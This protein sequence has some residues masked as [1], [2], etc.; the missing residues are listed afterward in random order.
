MC[1]VNY[2]TFTLV[3]LL[4]VIV[5]I[6]ILASV[7][8][9]TVTNAIVQARD[10]QRLAS[11]REITTAL[12]MYYNANGSYP[13]N[14]DNDCSGWDDGYNGGASSGDTFIQPLV[15]G[16]YISKTP[17]DPLSTSGCGGSA[18]I[19]IPQAQGDATP[20][21]ELSMF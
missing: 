6:A 8:A 12:E 10:A 21:E 18:I 7:V 15:D 19:D 13:G 4:V 1:S 2:K 3:E 16:G 14:T 5:I 17:G 9:A 20:Q 11:I